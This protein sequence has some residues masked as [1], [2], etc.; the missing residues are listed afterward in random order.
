MI[1]WVVSGE[2]VIYRIM[3]LVNDIHWKFELNNIKTS[4]QI[5]LKHMDFTAKKSILIE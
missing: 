4:I 2:V 5:Y 3:R 1:N